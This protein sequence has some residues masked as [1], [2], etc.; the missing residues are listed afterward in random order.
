LIGSP[1]KTHPKP[2]LLNFRFFGGLENR[3]IAEI[4]GVSESYRRQSLRFAKA[5]L[6]T[7]SSAKAKTGKTAS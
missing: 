7:P 5:W 6:L 4:M 2:R 1:F 3:E